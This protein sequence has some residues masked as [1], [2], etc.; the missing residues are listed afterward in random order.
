MNRIIQMFFLLSLPFCF[1]QT[2]LSEGKIEYEMVSSLEG[3]TKYDASVVFN[4]NY[5][6]YEYKP[7]KEEIFHSEE[8]TDDGSV[9]VTIKDSLPHYL[10]VNKRKNKI[11]EK[12]K[13]LTTK[14][15][16]A[17]E[18]EIPIINWELIDETK[19]IGSYICHK[20]T[21]TFRGRN[22]IAW[23]SLDLPY[24]IGPWK[25]NNL[26][27][28]ILE[29]NDDE[30]MVVF[31]LKSITIP[32]KS[33]IIDFSANS[34][35]ITKKEYHDDCEKHLDRFDSKLQAKMGRDVKISVSMRKLNT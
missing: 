26:P 11:F 5:S 19:T 33:E 24:N 22:Y 25:L 32:F 23:Y 35:K 14:E 28:M 6:L 3:L 20:A 29:A 7:S 17:I 12:A 21:T 2:S 31:Y 13:L 18:E 15:H 10:I 4:S 9:S 30:N 34:K 8:I 16:I 1:S 27:G